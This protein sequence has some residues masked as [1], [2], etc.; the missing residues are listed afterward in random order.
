MLIGPNV[1]IYTAG[2]P[3]DPG[4]RRQGLEFALPITIED[5]VWIGGHAVIALSQKGFE[6]MDITPPQIFTGENIK[7]LR[8]PEE[9]GYTFTLPFNLAENPE[10]LVYQVLLF[11]K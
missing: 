7:T 5:G 6:G 11:R 8:L 1:G 10:S 3:V 4:L 9:Q 2:H